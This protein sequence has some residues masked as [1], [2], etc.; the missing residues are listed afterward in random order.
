VSAPDNPDPLARAARSSREG[1]RRRLAEGEE[2]F[3]RSLARLGMLGWMIV[4]PIL[5]GLFL[6]RWLDG[7]FGSRNLATGALLCLGAALGW[8]FAWR[9]MRSG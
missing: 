2:P 1:R 6:G 8:W 7:L 9:Q 3:G 5:G 4:A